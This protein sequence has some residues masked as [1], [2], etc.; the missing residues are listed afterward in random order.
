MVHQTVAI[1]QG[2]SNEELNDIV[3]DLVRDIRETL[4]W[5]DV[6]AEDIV[7]VAKA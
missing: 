2:I 3:P 1:E 6:V 4:A 5:C 7:L